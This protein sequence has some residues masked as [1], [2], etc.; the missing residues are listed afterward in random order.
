VGSSPTS[1][2]KKNPEAVRLSG[3]SHF[4]VLDF[5]LD[6]LS[7]HKKS[8]RHKAEGSSYPMG[9]NMVFRVV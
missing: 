3:F 4:S 7:E 1:P 8:P 2:T 6:F 9:K 5:L